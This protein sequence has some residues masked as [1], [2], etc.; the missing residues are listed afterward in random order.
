[1]KRLGR[2]GD[3]GRNLTDGK[4]YMFYLEENLRTV[5]TKSIFFATTLTIYNESNNTY[6]SEFDI[7]LRYT[8]LAENVYVESK[9]H[10]SYW[11]GPY[12]EVFDLT[13]DEINNILVTQ[14][15]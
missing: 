5:G 13:Q 10:K 1:M 3:E 8:S 4:V 6:R 2:Y 7:F 12:T 9:D 11:L 14:L 15:I